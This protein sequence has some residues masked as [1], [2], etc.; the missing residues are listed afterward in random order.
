MRFNPKNLIGIDEFNQSFFDKIDQIEIDISNEVCN[1]D[2]IVSK[3][4]IEFIRIDNFKFSQNKSVIE[5]KIFELRNNNF[6][7]FES[8]DDYILYKIDNINQREPDLSDAS[9]KE[10]IVELIDQKNKFEYNRDL[11]KRI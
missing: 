2:T 1:I 3:Y 9:T 7:I 11:L 5:K 4:N 6:D 8:N 10:E